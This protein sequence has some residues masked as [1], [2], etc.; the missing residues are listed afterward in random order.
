MTYD[1]CQTKKGF[2]Y[3]ILRKKNWGNAHKKKSIALHCRKK[4][5]R[6]GRAMPR[7]GENGIVHDIENHFGSSKPDSNRETVLLLLLIF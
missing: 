7:L 6:P 2:F 4:H 3:H 1:R 5:D